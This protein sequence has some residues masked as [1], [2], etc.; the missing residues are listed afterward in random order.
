MRW[1]SNADTSMPIYLAQSEGMS[2]RV[3]HP[4]D[5]MPA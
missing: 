2:F 5:G 1:R 3:L 4:L